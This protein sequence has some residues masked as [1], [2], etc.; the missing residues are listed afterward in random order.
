MNTQNVLHVLS[1]RPLCTTDIFLFNE[2]CAVNN[3]TC[4]YTILESIKEYGMAVSSK[5]DGDILYF[6][7]PNVVRV[8]SN[9]VPNTKELSKEWWKIFCVVLGEVNY[10]TSDMCQKTQDKITVSKSNFK[11]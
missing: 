3:E 1:K 7:T 8:F 11:T 4:N 5:Y 9:H 6:E 2:R 10:V